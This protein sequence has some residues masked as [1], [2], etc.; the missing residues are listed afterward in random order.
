MSVEDARAA[1]LE[2]VPLMP[3]Q[4]VALTEAYGRILAQ[5]VLSDIDISPFD[6]SAMDGFALRF[7][8]CATAGASEQSPLTLNIVG[9]IGAG[10][11]YGGR[12]RSGEALRIMTGAPMPEGADTVVKIEDTTVVGESPACPEGRTLIITQM[13][14]RQEHVRFRGEEAHKGDVLLRKGERV[15]PP[16]AGLLASAGNAEVRV[17]GRPRVAIISIGSELVSVTQTPGPGQIRNS[18]S[19]SL[20]AAVTE[21][22][23]SPTI[24]PLVCD[25]HAAL[26]EALKAATAA[27]DFVITSGGAAEGDYDYVT[28]VVQEL[29]E[30]L[31]NKVNMRPG[32]SQTFSLIDKTPV[33]G[34]PGNPGAAS[35]GFELLIRPALRKMQGM[36]ELDRPITRAVIER[37]ITKKKETRR[38]YLRARLEHAEGGGYRATPLPNQSSALLG[39]LS[40]SN[41]LLI[42][43]EG[44]QSLAAGSLVDCLRI[45]CDEGTIL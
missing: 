8:D 12:L 13:P 30:M 7:E 5:D 15:T 4:S 20:A 39:A 25:T 18:N 42:V 21:A 24:Q 6:S 3:S 38:I 14:Q 17:Y 35:V 19:Y 34:L 28:A 33:F 44:E 32:K 40:R 11:V 29:G 16:A 26:A 2:R 36:S 23:A 22:G 1:L 37:D 27:Y 41:C 10:T 45:D 43:P 31:Y 9:S